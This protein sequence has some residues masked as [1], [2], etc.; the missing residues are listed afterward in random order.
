MNLQATDGTRLA[1]GAGEQALACCQRAKRLEVDG[2]YPAAK[3]ALGEL[4]PGFGNWPEVSLF[5]PAVQAEILWRVG[6]L[7][8]WLGSASQVGRTQEP[9]KDLICAARTIFEDLDLPEKVVEVSNDLALCY[10]REG[11]YDEARAIL[12]LA[13][14]QLDQHQSGIGEET[15]QRTFL[16]LATIERSSLRLKDA[17]QVHRQGAVVFENCKNHS[18]RGKFHNE[19]ATVLKN[20]GLAESRED[21]LDQALLEYAAAS[22]HFEQ[23]GSV[24]FQAITENNRG[25]LFSSIGRFTEAHEHLQRARALFQSVG[26]RGHTAQV[27]ETRARV[28]LAEGRIKEAEAIARSSVRTLQGGDQRSLLAESLTTHGTTLARLKRWD[29]ARSALK[30]AVDIAEQ[31]GDPEMAGTA[32][33]TMVEELHGYL[34]IEAKQF[35]LR[36]EELLDRS[37]DARLKERLGDCARLILSRE[38]SID[39]FPVETAEIPATLATDTDFETSISLED[40]VHRFEGRII[41]R[42]LEA[43]GGSVTRAARLLGITHQG[44]AFILN[45]RHKNLLA[46]RTPVKPRRR[47]IIRYR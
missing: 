15:H 37:Q 47:S 13:L 16:N 2:N 7:S 42:A 20:L 30:R 45:G 27:D 34:G 38:S 32:A 39:P 17:L 3:E 11:A 9:A 24:R 18:L 33:L 40:R 8:G 36:A 22:F 14:N 1:L 31:G 26:D 28:L 29:E 46:V 21:Y 35:Y 5:A 41:K 19:Y 43:S 4:W 10:W 23:S 12:K 25:F 44:L 6:S